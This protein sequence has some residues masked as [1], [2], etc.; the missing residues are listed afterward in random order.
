MALHF[1]APNLADTEFQPAVAPL[2][3]T[4]LNSLFS[5]N[6]L[7]RFLFLFSQTLLSTS[8]HFTPSFLTFYFTHLHCLLFFGLFFR[9]HSFHSSV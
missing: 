4:L 6:I 1:L 7:P 9:S 8:L 2:Y 3:S 5:C